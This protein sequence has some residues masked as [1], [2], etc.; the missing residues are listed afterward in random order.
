[1]T[2][3]EKEVAG[4]VF[5]A[6]PRLLPTTDLVEPAPSGQCTSLGTMSKPHPGGGSSEAATLLPPR[7]STTS[8][9]VPDGGLTGTST[10]PRD[11]RR[12]WAAESLVDSSR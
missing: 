11:E 10:G 7:G 12:I 2:I 3:V 9:A 5:V 4:A 8:A 6:V 1:M